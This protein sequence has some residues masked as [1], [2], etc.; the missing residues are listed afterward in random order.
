VPLTIDT[1]SLPGILQLVFTGA[2]SVDER[3]EALAFCLAWFAT[4][5]PRRVLVD[6]TAGWTVPS[7]PD[8]S[9]RHAE[10][11]AREYTAFGGARIA[12]LSRP[13]KRD[14]SPIELRAAARG[15]FY[16]RFTDRASAL[17]WLR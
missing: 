7:D 14:P 9:A 3:A 12:Y 4:H 6:C 11:L 13:E 2:I 10:N 1:D 16:Q 15:Y 8:A 5:Q 17:R